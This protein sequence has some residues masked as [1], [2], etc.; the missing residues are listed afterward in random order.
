MEKSKLKLL[1]VLDI[2]KDTD[3]AHPVTAKQI[4]AQ[5]KLF[6]IE[7]ERKSVL[8]DINTLTEYGYDIILHSDN[9]QGYY[10]VSRDFEDWELKVLCDAVAGAKFLTERETQCLLNKLYALS[11]IDGRKTLKAVTPLQSVVKNK[12]SLTKIYIDSVIT[13]IRKGKQISFLYVYTDIDMTEKFR[14]DGSIYNVNPYSLIWRNDSYY[15]I[16]NTEPYKDL[17]F[18]R[19]DRIRELEITDN[20]LLPAEELLGSNAGYHIAEYVRKS[21]YNYS[22]E[23]ICLTLRVPKYIVD[24]LIDFFGRDIHLTSS[25]NAY[26]VTLQTIESDG[27]YYWLLQYGEHITIQKPQSVRDEYLRRIK[28]IEEKYGLNIE[29]R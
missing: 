9:K 16:G 1:H 20:R 8:R 3:E 29:R 24:D 10:L 6:G 26:E 7:A 23:K 19:L 2:L 5:L 17:S 14:K 21:V 18:Y 4:I 13:A 11:G 12:T 22:G 28:K 25:E 27:L 15:L